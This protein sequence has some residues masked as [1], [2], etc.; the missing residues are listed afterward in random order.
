MRAFKFRRLT[1]V[2]PLVLLAS[3]GGVQAVASGS[4]RSIVSE[5]KPSHNPTCGSAF[6][7]RVCIAA[8]PTGL[9]VTWSG[10]IYLE[11][12]AQLDCGNTT[13][14]SEYLD[15]SSVDA[16][17]RVRV[18]QWKPSS[19][20]SV[21]VRL[22]NPNEYYGSASLSNP[23]P[24]P[25]VEVHFKFIVPAVGN[26]SLAIRRF[27]LPPGKVGVRYSY[28]FSATGGEPPYTWTLVKAYLTYLPKGLGF[29]ESGPEAGTIHGIPLK[30][31]CPYI[32]VIVHDRVGHAAYMIPTNLRLFIDSKTSICH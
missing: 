2:V 24:G 18:V 14:D 11:K 25:G 27:T 6:G 7:K 13:C 8:S 4:Q 10:K 3:L 17:L 15:V 9:T 32:A 31:D 12:S 26:S 22:T 1:V 23:Q 29:I 16:L 21:F 19:Y 30:V 20:H 5:V 28:R